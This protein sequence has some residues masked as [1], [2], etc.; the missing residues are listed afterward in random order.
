MPPPWIGSPYNA[1]DLRPTGNFLPLSQTNG[2]PSGLPVPPAPSNPQFLQGGRRRKG[3]KAN[4]RGG[5]ISSFLSTILPDDVVNMG[6]YV[7]A[8]AGN[9]MDKYN[10]LIPTASSQVYPTQQKLAQLDTQP[11][12]ASVNSLN[13]IDINGA[14]NRAVSAVQRI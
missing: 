3:K 5:G 2:V 9:L 1:G 13:P 8:G 11:R 7:T 12:L 14:Y 10:G 4:Q 6:R